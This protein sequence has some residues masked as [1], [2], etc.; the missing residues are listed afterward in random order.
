MSPDDTLPT[1]PPAPTEDELLLAL[2]QLLDGELDAAAAARLR[3]RIETEPAVA[4]RWEELQALA[5][6]LADLP[7]A[8][9]V[10]PELDARVL[11]QS[12]ARP[13]RSRS[14]RGPVLGGLLAL[15]AA[16]LLAV[17]LDQP[18]PPTLTLVSGTQRVQGQGLA[19]QTVDGHSITLDGAAELRRSL[20]QEPTMTRVLAGGAA[21]ALLTVIV[22]EGTAMVQPPDGAPAVEL[23]AGEERRF[24]SGS[25][26]GLR[27]PARSSS[28]PGSAPVVSVGA[29]TLSTE[30]AAARILALQDELAALQLERDM[31]QGALEAL[32]GTPQ[33]F[34]EDLPEAFTEAG[35]R[36]RVQAMVNGND[37]IELVGI[38]CDEY[39]CM[40]IV[41]DHSGEDGWM[42]GVQAQ[43]AA[44]WE[45]EGDIGMSMWVNQTHED[46]AQSVNLAGFAVRPDDGSDDREGEDPVQ[47]RT[48]WRM[49]GW[50]QE[51]VGDTVGEGHSGDEDNSAGDQPAGEDVE[52]TTGGPG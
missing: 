40:A 27:A 3:G 8:L 26:A 23:Q 7:P 44:L 35:V 29:E 34:P 30:E 52:Q 6:E 41:R 47:V 4:A 28:A 11:A 12:R 49:D 48:D 33:D 16:L 13:Q 45:D 21:G 20:P 22:Y 25:A 36:S 32:E 24:P 18:A 31:Q 50:M 38:D 17:V 1:A 14:G 15:A 42:R 19:I 10:P 43:A 2:S 51:V 37:N 46:P 39:P 5:T 9:A